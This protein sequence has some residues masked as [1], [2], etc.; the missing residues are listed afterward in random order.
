MNKKDFLARLREGLSGLPQDDVAERLTFY[1]EMID[2][3]V[4]DGL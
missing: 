4:E 2:D 3:K 1:A